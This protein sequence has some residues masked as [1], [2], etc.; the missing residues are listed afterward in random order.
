MEFS[1]KHGDTAVED[2]TTVLYA[3][4]AKGSLDAVPN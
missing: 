1:A 4:R 3:Y 2:Y